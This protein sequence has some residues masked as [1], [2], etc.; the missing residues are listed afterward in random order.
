MTV[1]YRIYKRGGNCFPQMRRRKY[2]FLYTDWYKIVKHN[3]GFGFYAA[4][5]YNYPKTENEARNIIKEFKLEL[6]NKPKIEIIN[7]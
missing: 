6:K 2:W 7:L 4:N 5:D 1:E 3:S